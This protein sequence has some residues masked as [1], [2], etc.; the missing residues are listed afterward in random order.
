MLKR[1][2]P[3]VTTDKS[4]TG[5]QA[6]RPGVK[7]SVRKVLKIIAEI[8]DGGGTPTLVSICDHIHKQCTV[9]G[10]EASV[11]VQHVRS[12]CQQAVKNGFLRAADKV[13]SLTDVG[14]Q[15]LNSCQSGT[16]SAVNLLLDKLLAQKVIAVAV[17]FS[18]KCTSLLLLSLQVNGCW[19]CD[20]MPTIA[21]T[22]CDMQC[23]FPAQSTG[24]LGLP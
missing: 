10:A 15:L 24:I 13:F 2:I 7:K 18:M 9:R 1:T 3:R 14:T 5:R 23:Y 4:I 21:Y 19:S 20:F 12:S 17:L 22:V 8:V 16:S 6:N 11:I